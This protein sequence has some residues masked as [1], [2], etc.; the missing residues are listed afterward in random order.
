MMTSVA[1]ACLV[2]LAGINEQSRNHPWLFMNEANI[3]RARE[4]MATDEMF[5]RIGHDLR[6][7]A[8]AAELGD[9]PPL[10][11]AWW[12]EAR[13]RPWSDTYP[14]INH[15]TGKVPRE[16]ARLANDC[17]RAAML[18]PDSELD[19]KGRHALLG[20]AD[21]T[22][23]FEHYDVGLNYATWGMTCLET[24]DLLY[25]GFT[26]AER[27]QLDAFFTRL[28]EAVRKNHEFWVA[29]EPGG[30]INNHYLWHQ[31]VFVMYGLFFDQPAWVANALHGPKGVVESLQYGFHDAGL[32]TEGALNYQIVATTPMVIMAELLERAGAS[33][34]IWSLVTDDGRTLRQSYDALLDILF[35][36]GTLP[37]VGDSYGRRAAPGQYADY[38]R[39]FSRFGDPRYA[40]ILRQHGPRS[41]TALFHGVATLPVGRPPAQYSAW[42]PEQGYI[43]L[44]TTPG[45]AYWTGSG[46]TLFATV[47]HVPCHAHLDGLS[48]M[49]YGDQRHWLVDADARAGVYH[50]FSSTIQRELNAAT[51]AHNTVLLDGQNQRFP[52]RP[53]DVVEFH[54]LPDVQRATIGDLDGQLYEGVRQLRTMIL[55]EA[56]VLDVFQVDAE[57]PRDI[58]WVVHVDG[59]G[60]SS[61]AEDWQTT[62][63]PDGPSWRWL[64]NPERAS[65]PVTT[66]AEQFTA[67]G[68]NWRLDVAMDAPGAVIRCGFPRD[69]S[70]AAATYATRMI[71]RTGPSAW[72]AA[73]YR[74][75]ATDAPAA[76][77]TLEPAPMGRYAA[78]VQFGDTVRRHILPRLQPGS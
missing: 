55:C 56:Y 14:V 36:D 25:A 52:R 46:W 37:N 19:A 27:E 30:P 65:E 29:H 54:V 33:E 70:P 69:D 18:F 49:L 7:R 4:A 26:P 39:L 23:E 48:I 68:R 57:T 16:W 51:L 17:A 5:A 76:H 43:M 40:W 35:P 77:V 74:T 20:L 64:R 15:H 63:L 1:W 3:A 67:D 41:E 73:L 66:Y 59:V 58:T 21:Y 2:V 22:F 47:S 42:W 11:R 10:E 53:L 34:R 38:E 32:W 62:V 61:S 71:R 50:A 8:A 13:H 31:L 9:L 6:D 75:A 44:R 45:D 24:Y 60:T 28:A 78:V 72:F 12:D